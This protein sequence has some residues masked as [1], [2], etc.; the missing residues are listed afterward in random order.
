MTHQQEIDL[1]KRMLKDE[2]VETVGQLALLKLS[3]LGLSVNSE[4]V[5]LSTKATFNKKRY[6]CIMIVTYIEI[7]ED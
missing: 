4:N 1:V 5:K 7:Q 2:P 6:E 3:E